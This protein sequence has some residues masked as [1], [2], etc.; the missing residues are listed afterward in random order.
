[1]SRKARHGTRGFSTFIHDLDEPIV[2]LASRRP[3]TQ[4]PP[5]RG[6]PGRRSSA[7]A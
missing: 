4:S 7:I 2:T 6:R 1:V 3:K 5:N